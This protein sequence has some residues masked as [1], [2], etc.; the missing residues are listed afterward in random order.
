M[1]TAAPILITGGTG[2]V[3]KHLI[4]FLTQQGASIAVLSSGGSPIQESGA[5]YYEADVR[6]RE[7][8][9]A[10]VGEV[11]PAKVYHLAGI[12]TANVS[13][14]NPRLTYEV[15]VW[16]AYNVFE[17]AMGL[18]SPATILNV[19]S[20]QVYAPSPEKLTEKSLIAPDSPYSASK[21]MAELLRTEFRNQTSGGVITARPFNHTG[22]G[23]TPNFVLPSMAKQFAEI[24]LGVRPPKL[25]LGNVG[26]KRDFSDVLD[27]VEAYVLLAEKGR[28]GEI[29]NV[30]SGSAIRLSDI[31]KMFEDASNLKVEV[32]IDP[33][34]VR[35]DEAAE[36]CGDPGKIQ[37]ETGWSPKIPLRETICDLLNYWRLALRE[38]QKTQA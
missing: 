28:P 10:I 38:E 14:T 1:I 20:S 6:N 27:V 31:I 22:P 32:E 8:V 13:W 18:P 34:K 21:A 33:G 16:G 9:Q 7:R 35:A 17:A 36:I 11:K 5:Q 15:N 30:C 37:S 29:Y 24:E 19:S 3:G 25:S 12:A 23:Q 4:Q 2:F 26:I